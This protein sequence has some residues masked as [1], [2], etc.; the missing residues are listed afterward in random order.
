M[1]RSAACKLDLFD[2]KSPATVDGGDVL[3]TGKHLIVGLSFRTNEAGARSLAEAFVLT[4]RF[5]TVPVQGALHL[6]SVMSSLDEETLIFGDCDAGRK[7]SEDARVQD[8]ASARTTREFGFPIPWRQ[9]S[10]RSVQK[11][12][13]QAG[14]PEAKRS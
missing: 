6:K 5:L 13:V 2:V 7:I 4:S 3:F 12:L 10:L 1:K 9:T 11:V 8:T 14:F